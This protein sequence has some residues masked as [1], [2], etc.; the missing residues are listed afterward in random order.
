MKKIRSV[1]SICILSSVL[2]L[3]GCNL[4]QEQKV[5]EQ[6]FEEDVVDE[7]KLEGQEVEKENTEAKLENDTTEVIVNEET[8]VDQQEGLSPLHLDGTKIVDEKGNLVQLRGVSTHGLAWFPQYVNQ[9]FFY[10]LHDEWN[11]NV[12]RLAMY[13]AESGG[14]CNGGDKEALKELIRNGVTYATNAELYV[15]I[16]W[17]VL[18]DQNPHTYK[19]EAKL[20]FDEMSKEYKDA[21]NVIYEICNEPNGGVGWSDV[22]SY[23][24]EIIPVIRANDEDAMIIVGTPTWSQDVDKVVE[25]PITGYDNIM[26]ALHFYAASHTDWLRER[27]VSAIDNGLPIFVTE[28]GTCDASGNGGIDITQSD[29]W[30]E[31]MDANNVSYVAWNL[32]NKAETSAIFKSDCQ[33]TYDFIIDDLTENGKWIAGMLGKK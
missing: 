12:V 27:M 3:T 5:D 17:H 20:F 21:T 19:E 26:Y 23:A 13:T 10:E 1:L 28:F 7:Q 16:D 11:A 4:T 32:S 30:I 9:D 15:I 14:Y 2:F 25:N 24:E 6:K 31:T 18:Q 29:K 22:K 8:I 33:K